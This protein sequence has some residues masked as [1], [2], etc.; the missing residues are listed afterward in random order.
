MSKIRLSSALNSF[1]SIPDQGKNN[2]LIFFEGM[3]KKDTQHIKKF[4]KLENTKNLSFEEILSSS[5]FSGEL[6]LKNNIDYICNLNFLN[7]DEFL[8]KYSLNEFYKINKNNRIREISK[9][10]FVKVFE[11]LLYLES[12]KTSIIERDLVQTLRFMEFNSINLDYVENLFKTK[13]VLYF[14][15]AENSHKISYMFDYFLAFDDN[16]NHIFTQHQSVFDNY[17]KSL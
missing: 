16:R 11:F 13:Q 14:S 3:H 17:I 9:K 15:N 6:S 2:L 7:R 1:L 8:N 10:D 12:S 5:F 4:L